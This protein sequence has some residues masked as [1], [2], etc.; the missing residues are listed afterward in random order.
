[1]LHIQ[2]NPSPSD[3]C[4]HAILEVAYSCGL[5]LAELRGLRL[6]NLQLDAGFIQVTGKGNK[7]RI[8]PIGKKAIIAISDYL[9]KARPIQ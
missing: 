7:Q 4:D 2:T 5:R 1:M 9:N 6:E 3:L 8:V